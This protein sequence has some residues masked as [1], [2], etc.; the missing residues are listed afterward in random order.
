MYEQ[1]HFADV[2]LAVQ[3]QV[4]FFWCREHVQGEFFNGENFKIVHWDLRI[5]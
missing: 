4:L 2:C 5:D 3:S 1:L